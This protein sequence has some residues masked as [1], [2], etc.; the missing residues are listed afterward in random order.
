MDRCL[1]RLRDE[2]SCAV[3]DL[4]GVQSQWRPLDRS[5]AWSIQQIV[6]HLLLTYASTINTLEARLAKGVPTR[7]PPTL[8]QRVAH[9]FV[10]RFGYFPSGRQAPEPVQPGV[11][12]AARNGQELTGAIDSALKN[13]D[14]TANRCQQR[15]G[16]RRAVTHFVLGPLSM[17]QWRKFHLVHGRHH[18]KQISEIKR[19]HGV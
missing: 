11:E 3:R 19:Q 14:E 17:A 15:F 13:L 7:K 5:K 2:L 9:L 10:F 4:D 1:E 8:M 18:L 16:R 6:E 12:S